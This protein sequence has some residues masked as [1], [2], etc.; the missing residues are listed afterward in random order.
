M[1]LGAGRMRILRMILRE[2]MVLL[3]VG[4]GIGVILV[5]A[6]GSTARAMLFGVKASDAVSLAVAMGGLALA[7]VCASLI[8]AVRATAVQPVEVLREE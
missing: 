2:A 6:V 7:A 1:A 4:L 5:L 3:V 8:P